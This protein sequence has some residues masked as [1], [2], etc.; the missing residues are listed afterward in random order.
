MS[1]E[2]HIID[3]SEEKDFLLGEYPEHVPV[4][5]VVGTDIVLGTR[6]NF[7]HELRHGKAARVSAALQE[8]GRIVAAAAHG[9]RS[10]G[11]HVWEEHPGPVKAAVGGVI[12]GT[13]VYAAYKV[14]SIPRQMRDP[15][16]IR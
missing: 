6:Q 2:R 7:D 11:L 16:E 1:K 15:G 9:A 3:Y 12:A 4:E 14:A 13:L 10:I 8:K 5:M